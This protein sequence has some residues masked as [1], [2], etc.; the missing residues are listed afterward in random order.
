MLARQ[1]GPGVGHHD[2]DVPRQLRTS[3]A[4]W[5]HMRGAW[6]GSWLMQAACHRGWRQVEHGSWVR[7]VAW[8]PNGKYV[9]SVSEDKSLRVW[10]VSTGGCV[11]KLLDAHQHFI[12][13]LAVHKSQPVVATGGVD[14][15]LQVWDCR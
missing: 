15:L 5:R 3:R 2:G 7:S 6:V 8:H 14:N 4:V 10:E 1:I 12:T 13:A 11:R 9:V